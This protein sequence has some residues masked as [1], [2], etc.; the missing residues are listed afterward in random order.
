MYF[1]VQTVLAPPLGALSVGYCALLTPSHKCV[2]LFCCFL[3]TSFLLVLQYKCSRLLLYSS[4]LSPR[5][6]YNAQKNL[7]PFTGEL[8]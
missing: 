6:S 8:L 5:I 7:L 2:L 1:I 4:C 3:S